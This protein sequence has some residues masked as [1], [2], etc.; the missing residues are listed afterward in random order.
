MPHL[1]QVLVLDG[2]AEVGGAARA[3]HALVHLQRNAFQL[4]LLR[5]ASGSSSER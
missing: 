3:R 1:L 2:L 5:A 4:L